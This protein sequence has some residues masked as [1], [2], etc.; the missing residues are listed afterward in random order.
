MPGKKLNVHVLE[1][2][3]SMSFMFCAPHVARIICC[4][5]HLLRAAFLTRRPVQAGRR[6][7]YAM[8][9]NRSATKAAG[10]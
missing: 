2:V 10:D 5:H 8:V 6:L 4:T 7:V 1:S 9:V 3:A